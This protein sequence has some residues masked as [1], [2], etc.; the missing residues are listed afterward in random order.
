[1]SVFPSPSRRSFL[2]GAALTASAAALAACDSTATVAA[3]DSGGQDTD[4]AA[5][6]VPFD[7]QHQAGISTPGQAHMVTVGMNLVEGADRAMV[8][9]LMK[10]WTM[11]AR[12]LTQGQAPLAELEGEMVTSPANLTITLGVGARVFDVIGRGHEQPE[13]LHPIPAFSKDQLDPQWGQTDFALQFCC[14]DPTTLAHA[15]RFVLRSGKDYTRRVWTQ[16]GFLYAAGTKEKGATPR[17]LFGVLDGTVNPRTEQDLED[18][19][20]ITDGPAWSVGGTAWVLRRIKLNMDTW[21]IVDRSTR[22]VVFGRKLDSG[23]PLTGEHEFDDP[24][25]D[26][27]DA[28]G[29]PVIDPDSHI[30][31]AH[32]RD[33]NT[34]ERILRR[35]YNYD[36]PMVES[37][38]IF[39]CFQ[40]NPD[41]QFT[42]IQARLDESDRLNEWATHIGSAVYFCPP[43]TTGG[44]DYWL[45]GL[46]G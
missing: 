5:Q 6:R 3:Q 42:P 25:F 12:P 23:A 24:D 22:E 39:T 9:R 46:L 37:G 19:V 4:L 10:V 15:V 28:T 29:L 40:Q 16:T 36:D 21:D 20:W 8:T 27:V 30:A 41:T 35:A 44:S 26:K 14:D 18:I 38:L 33:G 32:Y 17:N 11:A 7:G 43:G 1:M 34:H 45:S 2:T 31:R 13:W